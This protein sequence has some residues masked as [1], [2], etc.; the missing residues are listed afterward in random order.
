[1]YNWLHHIYEK[2]DLLHPE[3]PGETLVK[4]AVN[5]VPKSQSGKLLSWDDQSIV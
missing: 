4:L 5:G 1:M 3:Q 2:G